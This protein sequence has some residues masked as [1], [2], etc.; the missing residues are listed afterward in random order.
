[1]TTIRCVLESTT[2]TSKHQAG[3]KQGDKLILYSEWDDL[4]A[5]VARRLI[6]CGVKRGDRIGVFMAND[7]RTLVLITGIIRA[8][9]IACPVSTRLPRAGVIEQL[10]L[11]GAVRVVAFIDASKGGDLGG[12]EVLSPD[13][14]LAQPES[15]SPRGF[16]IELDAPAVIVFTSGSSGA[17]R[18]AVLTYANL[19]YN[20]R[21]ANAN[22]RLASN[23]KWLLNLPLYH[24]SGLGV[25]MRC[26]LAGACVVIPE[27]AEE[28][29]ASLLRYRPTHVSLVPSQLSDLLDDT[30]DNPFTSVKVFLVGGSACPPHLVTAARA[31]KWPVYLTYG[32]TEA[33]SQIATMPPDAPPAKQAVTAGKV[34]RH[35]EIRMAEDAEILLRGPCLF[36]G[37]W[38]NDGIDPARDA[39]GWF[40]TGD[41]GA[42]DAD[43]YLVV[44]GRKDAL[45]IS[46]GENIQPEEIEVHLKGIE[47]VIEAVVTSVP[48]VKYGERPVAFVKAWSMD[49]TGWSAR[50]AGILPKFKIPDA[51]LAW[52]EEA[53]AAREKPDRAWFAAHAKKVPII[54]KTD[55]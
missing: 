39:D 45:I 8:G 42:L 43:G 51:F 46:G 15:S 44:H 29:V 47:G 13:V 50:L 4:A 9:A 10:K 41:R 2:A 38:R 40:S 22:L 26:L 19:Y 11:I 36:A 1:M 16:E 12:L 35:R 20:A 52:P 54:G 37:Y 25:W 5:A 27:A 49:P 30:A 33:A 6:D 53:P 31:R 24:V 48:H 17:P 34:L 23:E 21:G 55:R 7:W 32:M 3:I 28:P 18:P 14:M